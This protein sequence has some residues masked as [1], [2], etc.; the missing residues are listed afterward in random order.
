[1]CNLCI[2]AYFTGIRTTTGHNFQLIRYIVF[3]RSCDYKI[4]E[5]V[6]VESCWHHKS[7]GMDERHSVKSMA[8]YDSC[9]FL[10]YPPK[11][12]GNYGK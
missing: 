5:G 11:K 2:I 4:P 10:N 3:L 7:L 8:K 12:V 1:M 9:R 6:Y